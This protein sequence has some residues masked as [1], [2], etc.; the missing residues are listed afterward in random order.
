MRMHTHTL[1]GSCTKLKNS[2]NPVWVL[3]IQDLLCVLKASIIKLFLYC[4]ISELFR[5]RQCAILHSQP[6]VTQSAAFLQQQTTDG[7]K[8]RRTPVRLK[9]ITFC[10]MF[11]VCDFQ[12]H[13]KALWE[14]KSVQTFTIYGKLGG[15]YSVLYAK[16]YA[17]CKTYTVHCYK[18]GITPLLHL[19]TRASASRHVLDETGPQDGLTYWLTDGRTY[20]NQQDSSWWVCGRSPLTSLAPAVGGAGVVLVVGVH[21]DSV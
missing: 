14:P 19:G 1:T 13:F 11:S 9:W 20:N 16:M 18:D 4:C 6:N 12:E 2:L 3:P 8:A 15:Y 7:C 5:A 10:Q 17:A 21:S